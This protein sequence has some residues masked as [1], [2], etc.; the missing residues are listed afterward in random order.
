MWK[1]WM[2]NDVLIRVGDTNLAKSYDYLT[3]SVKTYSTKAVWIV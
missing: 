1:A 2:E 3:I